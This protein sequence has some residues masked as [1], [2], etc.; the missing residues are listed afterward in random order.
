MKSCGVRRMA[1]ADLTAKETNQVIA[2]TNDGY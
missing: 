2:N 1:G